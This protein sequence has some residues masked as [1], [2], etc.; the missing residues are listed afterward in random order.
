MA[1][2]TVRLF[3]RL[4]LLVIVITSVNGQSFKRVCYFTSWSSKVEKPE[5]R[6]EIT[7]ID[8][9][10][11]THLIYAFAKID[12]SNMRLMKYQDDDDSGQFDNK[13]RFYDFTRLKNQN[14]DLV[15]LLSVGGQSLSAGFIHVV[16]T[17]KTMRLFA[18]NC[19]IFLRDRNFDGLD[20]DWEFPG[21]I[22]RDSFTTL[23]K[24][25]REEFA[26]ESRVKNRRPL[27][28]TIAAGVGESA[29]QSYDIGK[30]AGYVDFINL[31]SYD[32]HGVWSTVTSFSD[33]LYS[34]A[35]N[36][37]FNQHLSQDWAVHYWLN[38]SVPAEKIVMGVSV[39]GL[40]LV[41]K[42]PEKHG[43]GEGTNG[44]APAGP[45][46]L[47]KGKQSFPEICQTRLQGALVFWDDEQKMAYSYL[48]SRWTGYNNPRSIEVKTE[49]AIENGLGGLMFWS[50]EWDDFN[51]TYC[52]QGR[53][54][55]ISAAK[56][57]IET[58]RGDNSTDTNHITTTE[59]SGALLP[60]QPTSNHICVVQVIDSATQRTHIRWTLLSFLLLISTI[61]WIDK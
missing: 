55:I 26:R 13:G 17:S 48:G 15:T 53:F 21:D 38:A 39:I 32:F 24:V 29:I 52:G 11:C 30:I 37:Q 41:L 58:H 12:T 33:P 28:L 1:V 60:C 57:K 51:G 61:T 5:A 2:F 25:M 6:F 9:S 16:A 56:N 10:L 46:K 42:N 36:L 8:T 23:L 18:R 54:P 47:T 49:Y 31:M 4:S 27:L 14:P 3:A 43:M 7:D 40:S 50:L 44:A 22:Y 19:V 35:S 34:R 59:D 45:L 20:V